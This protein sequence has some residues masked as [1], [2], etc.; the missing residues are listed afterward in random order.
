MLNSLGGGTIKPR[1]HGWA[2]WLL[3]VLCAC[4][5]PLLLPQAAV[6]QVSA[7]DGVWLK[8][9][10]FAPAT[11]FPS[12]NRLTTESGEPDY[13]VKLDSGISLGATA[14]WSLRPSW[15][16]TAGVVGSP[17]RATPNVRPGA[18]TSP[19]GGTSPCPQSALPSGFV[20]HG[21]LGV[22]RDLRPIH[23]GV[24][25]GPRILGM[26]GG[27]DCVLGDL[28]CLVAGG[29]GRQHTVTALGTGTVG[30]DLTL[31]ERGVRLNLHH[32]VS[33]HRGSVQHEFVLSGGVLVFQ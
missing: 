26:S 1:V 10:W 29:I 11:W 12:E 24:G 20:V 2:R 31:L 25:I 4:A 17:T 33:V 21:Y 28:P 18:C 7:P 9:G 15:T 22:M 16:G 8:V 30:V 14:D 3:V 13:W 5:A 19:G 23:V 6:A 27:E 32:G